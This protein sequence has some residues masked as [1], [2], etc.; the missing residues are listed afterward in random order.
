MRHVGNG[1]LNYF[2][3]NENDAHHHRRNF[4]KVNVHNKQEFEKFENTVN[5][6]YT[7]CAMSEMIICTMF[8]IVSMMRITAVEISKKSKGAKQTANSKSLKTL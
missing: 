2:G 3:H 1:D 4:E 7:M 8:A 6:I 5:L